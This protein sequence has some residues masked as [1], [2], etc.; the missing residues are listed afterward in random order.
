MMSSQSN[1]LPSNTRPSS[2][3]YY[4][5]R[6]WLPILIVGGVI[7][8]LSG[9][10]PP[11]AW[12]LLSQLISRWSALQAT[13]GSA[14][15]IPLCILVVQCVL[16]LIA[17]GMLVLVIIREISAF[18]DWQA[19][20]RI[21]QLQAALLASGNAPATAATV[22]RPVSPLPQPQQ[23]VQQKPVAQQS[24]QQK[25]VAQQS[26]PK[27]VAQQ[28]VWYDQVS[29]PLTPVQPEPAN[30]GLRIEL[31][32]SDSAPDS[33]FDNKLLTSMQLKSR[34]LRLDLDK[35]EAMPP[36][37]FDGDDK[38]PSAQLKSRG[39]QVSSDGTSRPVKGNP[40]DPFGAKDDVFDFFLESDEDAEN[41]APDEE[42]APVEEAEPEKEIPPFLYGNP[43]EGELPE[44]F[45][46]D[47]DLRQSVLD[48]R[49]AKDADKDQ[50]KDKG[51][52]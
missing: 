28:S 52:A 13:Q 17:W 14:A 1:T 6:S 32:E 19:Q 51:K 24:V 4:L 45:R 44:V 38:S 3:T 50:D 22:N 26:V 23:A 37:P 42:E 48:I 8:W 11:T 41:A 15:L 18:K 31:D 29:G 34:G 35:P 9:G 33:P 49:D 16:L 2:L 21:V 12:V 30:R 36:N 46:Y 39:L 20:K 25:P 27:P 10:F 5:L 40:N 7:F 47:M 43:F